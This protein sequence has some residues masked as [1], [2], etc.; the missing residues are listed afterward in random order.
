M[1]GS[2]SSASSLTSKVSSSRR[3]SKRASPTSPTTAPRLSAHPS[4]NLAKKADPPLGDEKGLM[5]TTETKT[6]AEG[7]NW[8]VITDASQE[9]TVLSVSADGR[10]ITY[11]Y[12]AGPQRG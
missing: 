4:A 3:Q 12:Y 11:R 7:S 8:R 5:M 6:I 1:C 10:D 2:A 9:M